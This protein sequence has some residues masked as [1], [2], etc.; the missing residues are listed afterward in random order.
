MSTK[1][2]LTMEETLAKLDRVKVFHV[3][4]I[5]ADG[6]KDACASTSGAVTFFA[7]AADA[8][9]AFEELRRGDPEARLRLEL[10]PLGRAFALTQGLMGL[11][12]PMTSRLQ[13]S[14]SVVEAEGEAGVYFTAALTLKDTILS[15]R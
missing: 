5:L 14:Q 4:R 7:D 6:M 3:V 2:F 8:E 11:R 9:A 12:A 13:F 10:V 1:S 15:L